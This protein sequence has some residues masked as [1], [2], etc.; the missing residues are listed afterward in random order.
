MQPTPYSDTDSNK[1]AI[2]K[3]PRLLQV[4]GQKR[5]QDTHIDSRVGEEQVPTSNRSGP[6]HKAGGGGGQRFNLSLSWDLKQA[7]CVTACGFN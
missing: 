7:E 1:D 6:T 2:H 4:M 5:V 3:D